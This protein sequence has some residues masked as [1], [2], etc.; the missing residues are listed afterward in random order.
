MSFMLR[1]TDLRPSKGLIDTQNSCPNKIILMDVRMTKDAAPTVAE[2]RKMDHPRLSSQVNGR[3]S[4]RASYFG[5]VS[6]LLL[7]CLT[8]LLLILPLILPPLPPPPLMLLLFPICILALLMILAFMPSNARD[9][10]HAYT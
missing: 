9:F 1:E 10:A 5:L 8:A 7:I 2:G 4:L 6:L 3:K